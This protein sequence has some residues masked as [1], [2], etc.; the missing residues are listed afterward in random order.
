MNASDSRIKMLMEDNDDL[1]KEL[2]NKTRSLEESEQLVKKLKKEKNEWQ[3]LY[4]QVAPGKRPAESVRSEPPND[5]RFRRN[6][7]GDPSRESSSEELTSG[8]RR[9]NS[10]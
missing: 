2:K 10:C 9:E 3:E 1:T 5:K 4:L 6:E 7:G 8:S